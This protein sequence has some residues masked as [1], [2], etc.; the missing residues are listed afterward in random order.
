MKNRDIKIT[1][2][3][4]PRSVKVSLFFLIFLMMLPI[5][6]SAQT[7]NVA[8]GVVQDK[9]TGELLLGVTVLLK[10]TSTGSVTGLDG[11][12]SIPIPEDKAKNTV[13]VVSYVGYITQEVTV[14]SFDNLII[15]LEEDLKKLDELVVVGY[16]TQ[17]R[18]N[19]TGAVASIKGD[20]IKSMPVANVSNAL[21]GKVSGLVTKQ[22]SGEPGADAATLYLRGNQPMVLVDGIETD[23]NKVN[24]ADVESIT[25]LKD[26]SAVAPFGLKGANGVML[27]TTKRGKEGKIQ[28]SFNGEFGWQK[29]TNTPLFMDAYNSKTLLKE[30]YLTDGKTG[31]ADNITDEYLSHLNDGTDANPN[32]D[33]VKNYMGA[34]TSQ[35]YDVSI[36]GGN[37]Y[38]RA[39]VGLGYLKQGSMFGSS[40]G[41]DRY[42]F[43]SNFDIKVSPTT[44]F[45]TDLSLISDNKTTHAASAGEIMLNLYRAQPTEA[46]IYSNGLPAWQSSITGSLPQTVNGGGDKSSRYEYQVISFALEQQLPFIEGLSVKGFF[47]INRKEKNE[48]N[49]K[50][51]YEYYIYDIPTETYNRNVSNGDGELTQSTNLLLLHKAQAHINYANR[52]GSHGISGLLVYER[53]WGG[54]KIDYSARRTDFDIKIPELMHGDLNYQYANGNSSKLADDG[55]VMRVNYDY[56][57]KYLIEA[58]GRYDRTYHYAPDNR[59]A[60]FPSISLGW[61]VSEEP[62]FKPLVGTIDN[63]KLRASYG[64]SGTPIGD[65]YA[66]Y[67][68]YTTVASSYIWGV[69]KTSKGLAESVE[70]NPYLTWETVWKSNLG[71]DLNMWNGLLGLEF[72]IY[73]D[74]R[75]DKLGTPSGELPEEYG[76]APAKKNGNKDERYGVDVSLTN[77]II[78]WENLVMNNGFVFGFSRDKQIY[79]MEESPG[80]L[81][82]PQFRRTGYSA[83]QLRGYIADGLFK[84]EEE[85]AN[86]AVIGSSTKPGDI[87]YRDLNGD[88]KIDG[89]DQTIIGRTRVPEIMYGYTLGLEYKGFDLNLF[90]QGTGNSTFY[91]GQDASGNS[92]RGVRYP[93]ENGK[94]RIDH[95]E[96]WSINNQNPNA[97]YPR[98]STDKRTDNYV[99]STFW[100]VNSSYLK[101]KSLELGYNL[102]TKVLEKSKIQRARVYLNFYNLWTVFSDMPKD[103]DVENQNYNAYPQQFISSLG[104]SLTF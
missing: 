29:P 8:K 49:W 24:M 13:L 83:S 96:S 20:E 77:R 69:D 5:G 17:K 16:G 63:L 102:P 15:N 55:L 38:V 79:L 64:R 48:K 54:T 59:A 31:D 23:Y 81:N 76:V 86:S 47:N 66:W 73:R 89:Q 67:T 9:N 101:L 28:V 52:F 61:R 53:N 27:I 97:K 100:I 71:I 58:A 42:S 45:T 35:K 78:L 46:D 88:G 1:I 2:P 68:K 80:T 75:T 103:F 85:I 74:V 7:S 34:S 82:S 18:L 10:G 12:F 93:F 84:D 94:P 3:F 43:R 33:W 36:N 50:I 62:F 14:K 56:E 11:D 41:Y 44:L 57:Q 87:K 99:A 90:F 98:L 26:A 32:T 95:N 30:A 72:D 60:F 65:Q 21:G 104:V 91:L 4:C 19:M 40:Q 92:D 22:A 39:N 70:P 37:E 6:I 25:M 51:P